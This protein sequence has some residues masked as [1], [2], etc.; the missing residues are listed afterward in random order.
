MVRKRTSSDKSSCQNSPSGTEHNPPQNPYDAERVQ[1]L[2]AAA[3]NVQKLLR[4]CD[5]T[6]AASSAA[7]SGLL[8]GVP[9]P[10]SWVLTRM[11]LAG[12]VLEAERVLV[13]MGFGPSPPFDA[14]Q[15]VSCPDDLFHEIFR[16]RELLFAL[17]GGADGFAQHPPDLVTPEA[18]GALPSREQAKRPVPPAKGFVLN[19]SHREIIALLR[20]QTLQGYAIA[21]KV[22]LS[23]GYARK[24]LAALV[25]EGYLKN[26]PDGYKTLR[27]K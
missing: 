14:P 10:V 22:A 17:R 20:R 9:V 23:F 18:L 26:T 2:R 3:E 27:T 12:A 19:E 15:G 6:R 11:S 16:L 1:A 13:S 21:N 8:D 5:A 7:A 4:E 24:L 25:R